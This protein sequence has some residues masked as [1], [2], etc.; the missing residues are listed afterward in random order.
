MQALD[1]KLGVIYKQRKQYEQSVHLINQRIA[2][3]LNQQQILAQR[4]FPHYFDKFKTDGVEYNAFIGQSLVQSRTLDPL[5]LKNLRLW[6]LLVVCGVEHMHWK[7]K[8]QLPMPMD[9]TSLVLAYGNPMAIRFRQDERRFD[10]DGAYNVRYEILKK[11]IDKAYVKGTSQRLTQPGKLTI[12]Y[13]QDKEADEYMQY[14]QYLQGV[15]YL[16]KEIEEIEL[17]DLQ[18]AAGL[19]AFRINFSYEK[20]PDELI[21]EMMVEIA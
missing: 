13:S 5:H 8:N 20:S 15:G 16:D 1:P 18:G 10:V 3:Y 6:Q 7:I 9:I 2:E 4:M 14:L 12:V 21:R 17:E 19:Q 11:R